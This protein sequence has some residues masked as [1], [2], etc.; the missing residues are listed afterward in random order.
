[1]NVG[2]ASL[3]SLGLVA[4]LVGG[5]APREVP[6][7]IPRYPLTGADETLR[8]LA[9]RAKQVRTLTGNGL[10]TLTRP[11]GDSVRLDGQLAMQPP[12]RARLR[13]TKFD[14]VIIDLTVKPEGVWMLTPDDPKRKEQIAAAGASAAKLT[15]TWSVLSGGFFEGAQLESQTRG[16]QLIVRRKASN[17]PAI[18]CEVDRP[19]LTPR[20]YTLLDDAGVTRF[21]MEMDRYQ[22]FGPA[23][24]PMR[25][26][27]KSDGGAV[28]IELR[29]VEVNP[30]LPPGAFDPPRRAERLP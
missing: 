12:D 19:T 11:D 2:H 7:N 3:I 30:E 20:R 22:Q 6:E 24:W 28:V 1:M 10:V 27:A 15:R 18:V 17:E 21:T 29:E 5:C 16:D 26:T 13:A 8:L 25:L 9:E 23:V 4:A 14:R